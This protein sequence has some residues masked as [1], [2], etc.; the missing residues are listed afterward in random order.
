MPLFEYVCPAGHRHESL[1]SRS[2]DLRHCACGQPA[3][4]QSVYQVAQIR[5]WA[6]EFQMPSAMQ[7]AHEEATGYAAE[8]R[9]IG[10][11]EKANG[12]S[13]SK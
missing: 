3:R 12:F 6:S 9:T 5:P 4:R 13:L 2:V 7:A 11:E 10:A 1:Q 8:V